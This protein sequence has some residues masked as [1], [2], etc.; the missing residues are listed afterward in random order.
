MMFS[1]PIFSAHQRSADMRFLIV[2]GERF[3]PSQR[4]TSFSMCLGFRL[5]AF[6]C[7]NPIS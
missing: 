7:R 1:L 2:P 3:S 5:W 4:S 6:I